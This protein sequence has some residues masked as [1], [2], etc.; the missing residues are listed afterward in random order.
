MLAR[1]F[2]VCR[3]GEPCIQTIK[4]DNER[5]LDMLETS[6][7]VISH[8][9]ATHP[10]YKRYNENILKKIDMFS[11]FIC[12]GEV[13]KDYISETQEKM[14]PILTMVV[15]LNHEG[16]PTFQ[17]FAQS[18]IRHPSIFRPELHIYTIC[19]VPGKK[20][21][22]QMLESIVE[23]ASKKVPIEKV[24]L[25]SIAKSVGFYNKMGFTRDDPPSEPDNNITDGLMN[26]NDYDPIPMSKQ[27]KGGKRRRKTSKRKTRR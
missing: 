22:K 25:K 23:F 27:L 8:Y 19:T 20:L 11:E 24:T 26:E 4:E 10:L 2:A 14:M 1:L 13:S 18:E 21:G 12:R 9:P 16:K 7:F 3:R 5:I 6:P 17:G 15:S